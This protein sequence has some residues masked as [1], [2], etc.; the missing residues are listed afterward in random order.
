MHVCMYAAARQ[1]FRQPEGFL[2]VDLEQLRY[3]KALKAAS[4]HGSVSLFGFDPLVQN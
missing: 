2:W 4:P 1:R 3:E